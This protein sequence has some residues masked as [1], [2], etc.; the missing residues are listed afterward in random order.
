VAPGITRFLAVYDLN[1]AFHD[2]GPVRSARKN[3]V[4]LAAGFSGA[5]LHCGGSG[6]SLN[7]L[8][9]M[10][11]MNFDEIYGAGK[12]FYR[13][14]A[15][16]A[17]YNL[18]TNKNLVLQGIGDK[19]GKPAAFQKL[20]LTGEMGGGESAVEAAVRFQGQSHDTVFKWNSSSRKYQRYENELPCRLA[21]DSLIETENVLVL[22]TPHK[23]YFDT[24][25][26]EWVI[27]AKV[28]GE[29]PANF[30]RDGKVWKGRWE[31]DSSTAKLK[32]TVGGQPMYFSPGTSWVLFDELPAITGFDPHDQTGSV[33]VSSDLLVS[34]S[35]SLLRGPDYEKIRMEQPRG[36]SLWLHPLTSLQAKLKLCLPTKRR[37]SWP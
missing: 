27:Q 30:Y 19:N 10:P 37:W 20:L 29:G 25:A 33:D 34:L 3:L 26:R 21:D 22:S 23:K 4:E 15:R 5:F 12:Y 2:I 1:Q 31:K 6:E 28:T 9:Q 7:F 13:V 18:Y 24:V 16:P 17:P 35:T 32:F 11:L 36:R 14:A 8:R